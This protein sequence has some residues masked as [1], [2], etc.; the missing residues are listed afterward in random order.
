M[1]VA[2]EAGP[3]SNRAEALGDDGVRSTPRITI[4]AE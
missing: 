4:G 3:S 1:H 2:T